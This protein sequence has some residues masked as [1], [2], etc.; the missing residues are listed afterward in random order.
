[1]WMRDSLEN[2]RLLPPEEVLSEGVEGYLE[3]IRF[4][5][6]T[7]WIWTRLQLRK[8]DPSCKRLIGRVTRGEATAWHEF[9]D[10]FSNTIYRCLWRCTSGNRPSCDALYLKVMDA[11]VETG[12]RG[13]PFF[14]LRRYLQIASQYPRGVRLTTWLCRLAQ[15]TALEHLRR[16]DAIEEDEIRFLTPAFGFPINGC[17]PGPAPTSL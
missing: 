17:A 1:M 13:E 11:L 6:G 8:Q 16:L 12:P 4:G 3:R 14:R 7:H 15:T 2:V 10:R 9:V 5:R